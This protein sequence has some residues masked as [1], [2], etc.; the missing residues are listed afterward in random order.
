MD[1]AT[2]AAAWRCD[3]TTS[4]RSW[5]SL[6]RCASTSRTNSAND[7]VDWKSARTG[8][9]FSNGPTD[10]SSLG[11]RFFSYAGR[12]APFPVATT[13]ATAPDRPQRQTFAKPVCI[14]AATRSTA[15]TTDTGSASVVR[16]A[17]QIVCARDESRGAATRSAPDRRRSGLSSS[18]QRQLVVARRVPPSRNIRTPS[19]GDDCRSVFAAQFFDEFLGND[20]HRMRVGNARMRNDAEQTPRPVHE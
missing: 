16:I 20:A 10:R 5:R 3:R 7:C 13:V 12:H 1:R 9:T 6:A 8:S 18:V 14:R 15:S 2:S 4:S 17:R 19:R 11:A